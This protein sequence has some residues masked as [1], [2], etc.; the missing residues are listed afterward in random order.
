M[1][2]KDRAAFLCR[3]SP[4]ER[5]FSNRRSSARTPSFIT[6][7]PDFASIVLVVILVLAIDLKCRI[8]DEGD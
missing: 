1:R 5:P 4:P 6:G 7:P 2:L 8:E 3:I